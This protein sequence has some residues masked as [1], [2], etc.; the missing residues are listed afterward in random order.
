M[1]GSE[2]EGGTSREAA[3]AGRAQRGSRRPNRCAMVL[4]PA[5]E[6][7]GKR[8]LDLEC[9]GGLGAFKIADLVGERGFVIGLDS[10]EAQ[11]A[12]AVARAPEQHWAGSAWRDRLHFAVA[13]PDDL[14]GA[15][16]ED[17]SVDVVIINSVLNVQP[18]P[19][20]ALREI[21]RVLASGGY[22][23]LDAVLAADPLPAD[24]VA[25]FHGS[26]NVF[27]VAPT[28]DWLVDA[29]HTAG[30][31]RVRC[32]QRCPLRPERDDADPAL[33]PCAF[34]SAVVQAWV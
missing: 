30:F 10:D 16:I 20:A 8:V 3:R 14:R 19:T 2:L 29:L 9:R 13:R 5:G 34:T 31:T 25:R 12:R 33:T 27:G 22:L 23:Y 18:D 7:T 26:P 32:E 11:I 6:L 21:V 4:P 1:Q 28:E 17:A 24:I 15:G